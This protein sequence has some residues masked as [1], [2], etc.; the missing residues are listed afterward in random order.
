MASPEFYAGKPPRKEL[1]GPRPAP[2]KVRKDSHKIKK[3]PTGLPPQNSLPLNH[4]TQN[5]PPVIIYTVS[6]KVIHTKAS[7]FMTLVQSLTGVSSSSVEVSGIN[8]GFPTDN[9]VGNEF[10]SGIPAIEELNMPA[11]GG[12]GILSP[13]PSSLPPISPSW[14]LP[15]PDYAGFANKGMFSPSVLIGSKGL[16]GESFGVNGSS[17]LLGPITSPNVSFDMCNMIFEF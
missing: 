14:F 6:P 2:L 13:L 9:F 15:S 1:Q 10:S 8:G 5:R 17:L 7:D 11:S 4:Q 16:E 12:H 3:P